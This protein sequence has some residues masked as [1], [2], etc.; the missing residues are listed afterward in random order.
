MKLANFF[1]LIRFLLAPVIFCLLFLPIWTGKF[2]MLSALIIIPLYAFAEFTD[3]LDGFFARKNKQVTD[4]GKLFDP[5]A[6]VM[7]HLTIF[8]FCLIRGYMHPVIFVLIFYREFTM[9]FLRM[10]AVKKGVSV[11]ARKGGKLKTVLYVVAGAYAVI[12]ELLPRLNVNIESVGV[13]FS[14]IGNILFL[15]AMAASLLSFCDYLIQFKKI[16]S[17]NA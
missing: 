11:G 4:F 13:N 17:K 2:Q 15:I 1:T 9:N 7:L 14:L 12:L 5:F 6:D 3:F 16:F 10:L 8:C